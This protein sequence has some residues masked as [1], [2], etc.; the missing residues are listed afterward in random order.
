M[1]SRRDVGL[2]AFARGVSNFGGN[3][4]HVALLIVLADEGSS[5]IGFYLGAVAFVSVTF[6]P[7]NGFLADRVDAKRVLV[8][9]DLLCAGCFLVLALSGG[10]ADFITPCG[11]M[12]ALFEGP[13]N[14]A[15]VAALGRQ[16]G[17]RV[18]QAFGAVESARN[19]GNVVGP[20]ASAILVSS[21]GPGFAFGAN[22][23]TF[24][25]SACM[26]SLISGFPSPLNGHRRDRI[27]VFGTLMRYRGLM[28]LII[29]WI[30]VAGVASLVVVA[31]PFRAAEA[32]K[33]DDWSG[34]LGT[35]LSARALG[36]LCGSVIVTWSRKMRGGAF[37]EVGLVAMCLSLVGMGATDYAAMMV[38]CSFLFGCGDSFAFVGR[39]T[40]VSEM[41]DSRAL[42]RAQAAF[43]A[44]VGCVLTVAPSIGALVIGRLGAATAQMVSSGV[45][46]ASALWIFLSILQGNAVM[47]PRLEGTDS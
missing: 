12:S 36:A 4:A 35:M 17:D 33:S 27:A 11:V 24:A 44:V 2:F 38:C 41:V 1:M 42:G 31:D 18:S 9:C 13:S 8:T 29:A 26:I 45:L 43:D 7:L 39:V 21:F 10:R 37:T 23:L 19:V 40:L 28:R 30:A 22:A 6:A 3:G 25:L 47:A 32:S 34:L 16:S 15:G 20:A 14:T 46:L 5:H